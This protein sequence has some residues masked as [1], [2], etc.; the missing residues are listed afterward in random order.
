MAEKLRRFSN[1]LE[2]MVARYR[3]ADK[4]G[5]ISVRVTA[6]ELIRA[7][8][9]ESRARARALFLHARTLEN[10]RCF[11]SDKDSRP[12]MI[13]S[14]AANADSLDGENVNER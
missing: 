2:I 4:A 14:S 5:I 7:R 8:R 13:A 1:F 9:I 11:S 6:N 12:E 10:A 3:P